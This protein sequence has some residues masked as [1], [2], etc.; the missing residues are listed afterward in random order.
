[1]AAIV[2]ALAAGSGHAANAPRPD[3]FAARFELTLP[4]DGPLYRATLPAEAFRYARSANL[5]DLQVFNGNGEALP[6]ALF[7]P[8]QPK[9][10]E[11]ARPVTVFPIRATVHRAA[12]AGG[13]M[14]IR[15][16]A[17]G[18][19]VV[20]VDGGA[21]KTDAASAE[22][23]IA[24]YLIDARDVKEAAIALDLQADFDPSK[25]VPITVAASDDLKSWRT[26]ASR[27]PIFRFAAGSA[28]ET[29][30]RVK[31]RATALEG[32][33]LRVTWSDAAKF[34]LQGATLITSSV[35]TAARPASTVALDAPAAVRADEIEWRVPTPARFGQIDVRVSG[36][37]ELLPVT[38][39]GRRSAGEP[40]QTL[41]RGVVY[42]IERDGVE[43]TGPPLD[44][45][46]GSYQALKLVP[47]S[48]SSFAAPPSLQLRF[49]ARE[50][51]FLARGAG[52]FVLAVGKSD[53]AAH[54]LPLAALIPDYKPEAET[55]LPQATVGAVTVDARLSAVPR[56]WF[57]VDARTAVLWAVLIGAVL[58][59]SLLAW[60]LARKAS[61][62]GNKAATAPKE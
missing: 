39:M 14:E 5:T 10:Q 41:G 51:A 23:R 60:S 58:I 15:Q 50:V 48:G 55:A 45:T 61:A 16:G 42:R 46:A 22:D 36:T 1:M 17:A 24:A 59:L 56:Q 9:P 53:A 34:E 7:E 19:T 27:E 62:A 57:G 32:Q 25:L 20:V 33:F 12:L 18:T 49:A 35:P 44:V 11:T 21:K 8:A 47:R 52:P 28:G 30:T 54:A 40:W 26:L 13:R 29:R 6:F 38:V 31:W 37:N 43:S 4:A 3:E 2:C